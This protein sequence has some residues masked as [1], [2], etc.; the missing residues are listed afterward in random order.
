[1]ERG[2]FLDTSLAEHTT[3]SDL[4]ELYTLHILP[5]KR[6]K[7]IEGYRIQTL[8]NQLGT[9]T[10]IQLRP[11]TVSQYR[12]KRLKTVQPA[13]VRRELGLLSQILNTAEKEFGIDRTPLHI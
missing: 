4:L 6:G 3:L 13:T 10:L 9:Y 8:K 11:H 7:D 5:S 1:M 2:I 12:D